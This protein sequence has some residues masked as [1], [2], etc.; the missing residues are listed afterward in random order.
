MISSSL[1]KKHPYN[2]CLILLSLFD[3]NGVPRFH[4]LHNKVITVDIINQ[5]LCCYCI[6]CALY[7]DYITKHIKKMFL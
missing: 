2:P 7:C 4:Y 3:I 6:F 1:L 5:S